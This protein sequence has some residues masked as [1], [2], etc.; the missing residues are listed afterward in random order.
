MVVE[1]SGMQILVIAC[2]FYFFSIFTSILNTFSLP[3]SKS[4]TAPITDL[5]CINHTLISFDLHFGHVAIFVALFFWCL[6]KKIK[7]AG[8]LCD[9]FYTRIIEFLGSYSN[10][11]CLKEVDEYNMQFFSDLKNI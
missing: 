5:H 7:W 3:R 9:S 4:I 2:H 8:L 10:L 11:Y 1:Y 6:R